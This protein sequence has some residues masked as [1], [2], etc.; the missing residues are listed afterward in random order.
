MPFSDTRLEHRHLQPAYQFRPTFPE[1]KGDTLGSG[2]GFFDNPPTGTAASFDLPEDLDDL[3]IPPHSS[4]G[5]HCD[6]ND[7]FD[8]FHTTF[9]DDDASMASCQ[10]DHA[11]GPFPQDDDDDSLSFVSAPQTPSEIAGST[12]T[13]SDTFFSFEDTAD[14]SG[15]I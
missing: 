3:P 13:H 4:T 1:A 8:I 9:D 2:S 15:K 12:G 10:S 14:S 6:D 5:I 7:C 11:E